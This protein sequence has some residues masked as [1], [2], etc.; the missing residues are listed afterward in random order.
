MVASDWC[1]STLE[2]ALA[3]LGQFFRE[4]D[5]MNNSPSDYTAC[6]LNHLPKIGRPDRQDP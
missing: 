2:N 4:R 6:N 5:L 3:D 1:A